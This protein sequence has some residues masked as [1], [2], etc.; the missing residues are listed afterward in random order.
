MLLRSGREQMELEEAGGG[1]RRE[2]V[3]DRDR[4]REGVRVPEQM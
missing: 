1:T 4:E 2:R 3:R